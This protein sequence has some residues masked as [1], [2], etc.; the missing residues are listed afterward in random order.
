MG[1]KQTPKQITVAG[2]Q[3]E[4]EFLYD[5][6]KSLLTI[7]KPEISAMEDWLLIFSY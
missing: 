3:E 4:L 2:R 6:E 5:K 1:V 7:R